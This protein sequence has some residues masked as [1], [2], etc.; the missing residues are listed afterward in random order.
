MPTE[1]ARCDDVQFIQCLIK[2]NVDVCAGLEYHI[3]HD[4]EGIRWLM[5]V[6]GEKRTSIKSFPQDR[7]V[8]GV[9]S[10]DAV[11]AAPEP[12][13]P[14]VVVENSRFAEFLFGDDL[15]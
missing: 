8:K 11:E 7:A 9:V 14:P 4:R 2:E 3:N 15:K 1:S 6:N 5:S 12:P 13:A 10:T